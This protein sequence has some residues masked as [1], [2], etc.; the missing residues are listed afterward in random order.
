MSQPPSLYC[1]IGR[2]CQQAE[3]IECRDRAGVDHMEPCYSNILSAVA[4]GPFSSPR[5]P[6]PTTM[7]VAS[8]HLARVRT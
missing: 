3:T 4:E 8:L 7:S 5:L 2:D 6:L 1:R